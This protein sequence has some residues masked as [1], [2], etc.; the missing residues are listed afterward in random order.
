MGSLGRVTLFLSSSAAEATEAT[1]PEASLSFL[2]LRGEAEGE[3]G[4]WVEALDATEEERAR[5]GVDLRVGVARR[6]EAGMIATTTTAAAARAREKG[7]GETVVGREMVRTCFDLFPVLRGKKTRLCC[8]LS[9]SETAPLPAQQS[10]AKFQALGVELDSTFLV[11]DESSR[12]LLE[13]I[14]RTCDMHA[15]LYLP[16]CS[17][18]VA[19]LYG[20]GT[21]ELRWLRAEPQVNCD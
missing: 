9:D 12:T 15:H 4:V 10:Q 5:R 6:V 3:A 14:D 16:L 2:D 1:I 8:S 19:H 17:K 20:I 13:L 18:R 7:K 21:P 11:R